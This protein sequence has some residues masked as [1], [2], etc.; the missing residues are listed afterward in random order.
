MPIAV[1]RGLSLEIYGRCCWLKD[2]AESKASSIY[3]V[4]QLR[5]NCRVIAIGHEGTITHTRAITVSRRPCLIHR[6]AL[7]LAWAHLKAAEACRAAHDLPEFARDWHV[8]QTQHN[9]PWSA[10][11]HQGDASNEAPAFTEARGMGPEGDHADPFMQEE[12][13][14]RQAA[15]SSSA[16]SAATFEDSAFL[17]ETSGGHAPEFRADS[18]DGACLGSQLAAIFA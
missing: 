10:A 15:A 7:L 4:A 5:Q 14:R 13:P 6:Q 16:P 18:H 11:E 8:M 2:L 17:E 9:H 3:F 1:Q 12:R